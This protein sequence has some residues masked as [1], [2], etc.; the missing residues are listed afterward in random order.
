MLVL[1]RKNGE[2]IRIGQAVEVRVLGIQGGRVKL[3]FLA[4]DG[5]T[6]FR[7][8]ICPVAAAPAAPPRKQY[9]GRELVCG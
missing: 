1:T 3:G 6:I 7:K 2:S 9:A 5:V 8:E 4:P